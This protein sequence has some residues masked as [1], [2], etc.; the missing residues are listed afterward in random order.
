MYSVLVEAVN[1][2]QQS[3]DWG[4]A[5]QYCEIGF[6]IC[7]KDA[8]GQNVRG[9]DPTFSK[10]AIEFHYG[11]FLLGRAELDSATEYFQKSAYNFAHS[12]HVGVSSNSSAVGTCLAYWACGK[13]EF[14]RQE[15]GKALQAYQKALDSID[16]RDARAKELR[17]ILEN[18][19]AQACQAIRQGQHSQ[20]RNAS[21]PPRAASR[22]NT[23]S[24]RRIPILAKIAAGMPLPTGDGTPFTQIDPDNLLGEFSLDE[25]H[26]RGAT[27]GL[28]IKGDSM[29]D[30][31]IFDGDWVLIRPQGSPDDNTIIAAQIMRQG[32]DDQATLK[33][34]SQREG[35]LFLQSMSRGHKP[36]IVVEQSE[37]ERI[38]REYARRGIE[39]DVCIA[40]EVKMIGRVVGIW[41]RVD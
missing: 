10:A 25:E 1:C 14:I 4:A 3:K 17:Q 18:E 40:D 30:A 8:R 20:N 41:R 12:L 29:R 2:A 21:A 11:V 26:A 7:Q 28:Q 19:I 31:G 35:H 24:F 32:E 9:R 5:E 36:I 22:S 27:F 16:E 15:W 6:D 38:V 39:V 34:C 23:T 33:K 13:V 37:R